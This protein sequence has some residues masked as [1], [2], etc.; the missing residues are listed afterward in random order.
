MFYYSDRLGVL[1][2]TTEDCLPLVVQM[3]IVLLF[4][5]Q[6]RTGIF[7]HRKHLMSINVLVKSPILNS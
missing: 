3:Y 1:V 5:P 4:S 6:S 7:V 2:L